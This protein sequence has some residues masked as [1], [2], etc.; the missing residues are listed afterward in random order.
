MM[1]MKRFFILFI[2]ISFV[3]VSCSGP[4]K[5]GWTKPD[6]RQD[7]FKKDREECLQAAKNDQQAALTFEE[8][9]A[10]KGYESEPKPSSDKEKGK[11][12]EIAKTVGKVLLV[13]AGVAVL[14]AAAA[15]L[16]VL[17]AFGGH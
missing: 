7:E 15:A 3:T 6:F 13:T 12:V 14:V 2:L 1:G 10:K 11:T 5:V 4:N 9:L 16:A 8:C 17:G